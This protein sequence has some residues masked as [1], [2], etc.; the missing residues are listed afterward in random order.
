MT[1]ED[2]EKY[3]TNYGPVRSCKVAKDPVSGQSKLYG[4]VWFKEARDAN[5]AML[6]YRNSY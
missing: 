3:F 2:L 6:D 1:D 5:K 4:F